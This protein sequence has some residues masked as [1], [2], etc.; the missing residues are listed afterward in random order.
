MTTE[1]EGPLWA[2][3]PEVVVVIPCYDEAARFVPGGFD[4][5]FDL[6]GLGAVFVD[7]GST[8]GTGERIDAVMARHPGRVVSLRHSQNRG[9]AAAV[10]TGLVHAIDAGASWVGYLDADLSTPVSEWVR[11]M[12]LRAA[13][14]DA[15]LASRV[16]LLGRDVER[17]P[18]RH[19]IGRV[20]AT[21]ASALVGLGVYDTQCGAKLFR[22]TP[23]LGQALAL[24]FRTRWLFDVEL[25]ARLLYPDPGAVAVDREAFV[26]MPLRTWRDVAGSSLGIRSTGTVAQDVLHLAADVRRRRHRSR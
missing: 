16:R 10:R 1:L 18:E 3:T 4:G 20:F 21:W 14:I 24:P 25:L 17:R 26:E 6:E 15:V 5:L 8:D 11:L 12:T 9:K 2:T 13:G 7:D 22:V 23:T 19:V